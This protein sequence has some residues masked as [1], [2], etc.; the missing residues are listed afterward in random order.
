MRGP[1]LR[2]WRRRRG[3]TGAASGGVGRL[4]RGPVQRAV[5][6]KRARYQMVTVLACRGTLEAPRNVR[7]QF[8]HHTA[9]RSR[10]AA[11]PLRTKDSLMAKALLGH[12]GFSAD[13]RLVDEVRRLRTLVARLEAELAQVRAVND[14]LAASVTVEDDLSTLSLSEAHV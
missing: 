10:G 6:A 13:V 8:E 3:P 12:V 14:V 2:G 11:R 9:D 7:A 4:D 1:T 5:T